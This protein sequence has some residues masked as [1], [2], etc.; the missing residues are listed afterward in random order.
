MPLIWNVL[1]LLLLIILTITIII[2]ISIIIIHMN[3]LWQWQRD[4][5]DN[6]CRFFSLEKKN[7][8]PFDLLKNAPGATRLL[9]SHNLCYII[10]Y[11]SLIV[12]RNEHS[13][14]SLSSLVFLVFL[15]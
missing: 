9:Q 4:V 13:I 11:L 14:E 2:I 8:P 3:M 7:W 10:F 5:V 15:R 1:L 12:V 6:F